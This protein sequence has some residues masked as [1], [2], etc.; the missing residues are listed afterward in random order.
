MEERKDYPFRAWH[1]AS[2][3]MFFVTTISFVKEQIFGKSTTGINIIV[4]QLKNFVLMEW[5]GVYDKNNK[6][7]YE[8][9]LV[10]NETLGSWGLIVYEPSMFVV[11]YPGNVN[12]IITGPRIFDTHKRDLEI[13]G[14]MF[15]NA[16]L[17]GGGDNVE[18]QDQTQTPAPEAP[19]ETP[20]P[21]EAPA[22]DP[23]APEAMP[24]EGEAPAPEA[25]PAEETPP[26]P[27]EEAPV[28][29]APAPAE[30]TPAEAP[31]PEAPPED[32]LDAVRGNIHAALVALRARR[33]EV[34][35]TFGGRELSHAITLLEDVGMWVNRSAFAD[36]PYDPRQKMKKADE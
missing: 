21:A 13:R 26:A 23:A 20:A 12:I 6:A 33:D 31:A 28:D 36:E 29:P 15:Q 27:A 14:N 30:E 32:P 11:K 22:S 9:D 24:P 17:L 1:S 18:N 4:D 16:D 34:Q 2:R 8:G 5:A 25:T 10:W 35:G 7:I 19:A 3:Q